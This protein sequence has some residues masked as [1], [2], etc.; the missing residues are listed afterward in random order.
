MVLPYVNM[1]KLNISVWNAVARRYAVMVQGN[2]IAKIQH[3]PLRDKWQSVHMV[4]HQE[5]AKFA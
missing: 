4:E 1:V 5:A 3:V 2:I